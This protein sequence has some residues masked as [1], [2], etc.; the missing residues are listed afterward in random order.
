MS[1]RPELVKIAQRDFRQVT[2]AGNE[3][4]K[5]ITSTRDASDHTGI[6]KEGLE[7]AIREYVS[8]IVEKADLNELVDSNDD[9]KFLGQLDV[10]SIFEQKST[11][12]DP[13]VEK[14]SH[15]IEQSIKNQS[16]ILK[17]M[18]MIERLDQ[19]IRQGQG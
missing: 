9:Y 13:V 11:N 14:S 10:K 1:E 6:I 12:K 3:L 16:I 4:I 19:V 15:L 17:K 18:E 2:K 7:A 8:I 5:T